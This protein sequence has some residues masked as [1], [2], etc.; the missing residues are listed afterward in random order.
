MPAAALLAVLLT[1]CVRE[2]AMYSQYAASDQ[3]F[4]DR[5]ACIQKGYRAPDAVGEGGWSRAGYSICMQARGW[6]TP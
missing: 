2:D 1:G 5:R 6:Q 4:A 3:Y